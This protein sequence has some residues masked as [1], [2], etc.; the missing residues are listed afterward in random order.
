[1]E[2][3]T[4]SFACLIFSQ[5][6]E[7]VRTR[8]AR[9]RAPRD[10]RAPRACVRAPA[11]AMATSAGRSVRAG[12]AASASLTPVRNCTYYGGE[13]QPDSSEELHLLRGIFLKFIDTF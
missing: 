1:M 12:T 3:V 4:L 10:G 7:H 6:T 11:V 8:A 13:C 5:I 2:H 9:A